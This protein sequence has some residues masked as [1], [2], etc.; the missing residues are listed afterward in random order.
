MRVCGD[1]DE[2]SALEKGIRVRML[3]LNE[4]IRTIRADFVHAGDGWRDDGYRQ[5]EQIVYRIMESVT[6]HM[7]DITDLLRALKEYEEVLRG[8]GNAGGGIGMSRGMGAAALAAAVGATISAGGTPLHSYESTQ[9]T[10]KETEGGMVYDS[11]VET[12]E[13]LDLDQGKVPQFGGTCGLCSCEN[14]LRLAGLK[15]TEKEVVDYASE[16]GLCVYRKSGMSGS[17]GGTSA[18]DRQQILQH[19]GLESTQMPGSVENI[20]QAV[21]EGRGVIVSVRAGRLWYGFSFMPDFHAVTVTS[22]KKDAQGNILGFYIADS[23]I[24][25]KDGEGYYTLKKFKRALTGR[26]LNVTSQII[27]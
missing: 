19:F 25:G 4:A 15:V 7:D 13:I 20:A 21:S 14:V 22:V 1:A 17:N 5:A 24:H 8:T 18:E 27:R 9:E 23:G 11:P 12:R 2:V 3:H 26:P 10:W 6:R 16:N